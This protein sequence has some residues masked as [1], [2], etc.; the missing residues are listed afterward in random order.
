MRT[1][2]WPGLRD[3]V[4]HVVAHCDTCQRYEFSSLLP[5]GELQPLPTPND[6]FDDLSMDF[7]TWLSESKT[8]ATDMHGYDAIMV[9]VDRLT[10]HVSLIPTFKDVSSLDLATLLH[11]EEESR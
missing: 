3:S 8:L 5:A 9:V 4:E 6:N 11:V 2:W 1:Y 7:M 10:K